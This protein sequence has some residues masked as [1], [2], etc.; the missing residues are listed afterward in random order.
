MER[1]LSDSSKN[2]WT[3]AGEG[4]ECFING[5]QAGGCAFVS[6]LLYYNGQ[7]YVENYYSQWYQWGGSKFVSVAGDPRKASPS[8]PKAPPTQ[9]VASVQDSGFFT[10]VSSN[11]QSPGVIWAVGR[12]KSLT[13]PSLT[14]YAYAATP[15]GGTLPM[16]YSSPAGAWPNLDGDADAVP[17]VANGQVYVASYRSLSIFGFG[18]P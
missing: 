12:P 10:S 4:D 5:I 8:N 14:L 7:I 13:T 18:A 2:V 15:S 16:L 9:S 1:T 11:G 17:V 6:T 3:V